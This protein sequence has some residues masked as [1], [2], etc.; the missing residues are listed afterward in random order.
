MTNLFLL[1]LPFLSCC[2]STKFEAESIEGKHFLLETETNELEQGQDYGGDPVYQPDLKN[3]CWVTSVIKEKLSEHGTED[4]AEDGPE[5]GP[6]EGPEDRQ[7]PELGSEQTCADSSGA[8]RKAGESWEEEVCS[9]DFEK[10][11]L[12][13]RFCAPWKSEFD[14]VRCGDIHYKGREI[15]K[16]SAGCAS[17]HIQSCSC[18][19]VPD[20]HFIAKAASKEQQKDKNKDKDK[21]SD[22]DKDNGKDKDEKDKDEGKY[23]DKDNG[24]DKDKEDK[25]EDKYKGK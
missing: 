22:K 4:G 8:R 6:E 2:F 17:S 18:E 20:C 10:M 19:S 11:Q 1:I 12:K 25:D 21:N 24:K 5:E 23:K 7:E 16:M 15:G 14:P 13:M 9:D 3:C